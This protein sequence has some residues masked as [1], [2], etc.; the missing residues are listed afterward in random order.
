MEERAAVIP[1]TE[2]PRSMIEADFLSANEFRVCAVLHSLN[3]LKHIFPSQEELQE[4]TGLKRDAVIGAI[5]KLEEEGI[6]VKFDQRTTKAGRFSTNEYKFACGSW[7]KWYQSRYGAYNIA[8]LKGVKITAG[9]I[10][11]D[12]EAKIEVYEN[13]LPYVRIYNQFLYSSDL[14]SN[15]VRVFLYLKQF[16]NCREIYPSYNTLCKKTGL[17]KPTI[18]KTIAS[19]SEKTLLMKIL[20]PHEDGGMG[21]NK[22][23]IANDEEL[24]Q[25]LKLVA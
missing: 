20:Q 8:T 9:D 18:I 19:L 5:K 24:K 13:K 16:A 10:P 4:K 21:S 15:E 17:S 1:Y 7:D 22:Y 12:G 14:N 2:V 25:W 6:I 23:L 11:Q 3:F